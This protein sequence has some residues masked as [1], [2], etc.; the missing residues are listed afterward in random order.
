MRITVKNKQYNIG[1]MKYEKYIPYI[2]ARNKIIKKEIYE[3]RD[4]DLMINTLVIVFDNQFTAK[5]IKDDMDISDIIFNFL[6]VDLEIA[7]KSNKKAL[8]VSEG[9]TKGKKFK[10]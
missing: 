8:K 6:N 10:R 2:E 7:N 4:I 9:F 5:D 3:P 1:E